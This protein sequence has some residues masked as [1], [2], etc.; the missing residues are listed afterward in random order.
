MTNIKY[1]FSDDVVKFSLSQAIEYKNIT[2]LDW[3]V[4]FCDEEE[5]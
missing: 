5:Y 4:I 1:K 2:G 3:I